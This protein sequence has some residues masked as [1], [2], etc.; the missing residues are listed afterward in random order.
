M[1]PDRVVVG[2]ETEWAREKLG[3]LFEPFV[4]TGNPI[5]FM[6]IPSAEI[7]KYAANT[8][9]ATRISFMNLISGLCDAAGADVD[10]V[11]AG[12]GS[13]S[14]I[15]P[16]FLFPGVGFGGSCLPKDVRA[17]IRTCREFGVPHELLDG[18]EAVNE[19]QKRLILDRVFQ[20]FGD[21]LSG[22]TFALWGLSFK[23]NTDDMREAPSLVTI[24]GLLGAG[25][26]V[27]VHDPVAMKEARRMLGDRIEYCELNYDAL[28][29]ADALLI[30]TE[31]QPYRRPDFDRIRSALRAPIIIDGR[32]LFRPAKMRELGFEYF[33]IGR[34]VQ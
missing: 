1:K 24:E 19:G 22:R 10:A 33:S 12:V 15:G 14:R 3:E 17:L 30:H 7:T 23:P 27:V 9:L 4:R 16:S 6:D 5:L 11:R 2:V 13:D 8:M 21:D 32:N 31:W 29:G 28:S 34:P 25:A 18:V 26:R 20:I